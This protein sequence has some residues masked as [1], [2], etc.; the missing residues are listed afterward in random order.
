MKKTKTKKMQ[1]LRAA[2]I[3]KITF[4]SMAILMGMV[5]Y[6]DMDC[7]D[8]KLIIGKITITVRL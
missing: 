2:R 5:Q 8:Y 6:L 4:I 3:Q 1:K 7:H